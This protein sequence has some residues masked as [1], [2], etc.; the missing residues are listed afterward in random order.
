MAQP[1]AAVRARFN[2]S[3]DFSIFIH[4][5]PASISIAA[6]LFWR[7]SR[8]STKNIHRSSLGF[9][10]NVSKRFLSGF[11]TMFRN[12][13]LYSFDI[14]LQHKMHWHLVDQHGRHHI[15]P[16]SAAPCTLTQSPPS[17]VLPFLFCPSFL[18]HPVTNRTLCTNHES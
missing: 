4:P 9:M 7:T 11:D 1:L 6:R 12:F 15:F 2:L 16:N 10:E 14:H 8:Q 13:K 5:A 3:T 17:Q 18:P